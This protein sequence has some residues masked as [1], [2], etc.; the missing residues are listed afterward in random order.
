M[1]SWRFKTLGNAKAQPVIFLHGFLGDAD[2]WKEVAEKL[3]ASYYCILPELPGHGLEDAELPFAEYGFTD[4]TADFK[5]FCEQFNTPR[6]SVVAYSL[7][8]RLAL[9][10]A[11]EYPALISKL[12]L[13]SAS[14]GIADVEARKKR[15]LDDEQRAKG[16]R[17]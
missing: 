5:V 7:G 15:A 11:L 14:A 17:Y 3:A 9:A 8:G 10:A 2:D 16:K 4:I 6:L 13:V 12:V 1:S